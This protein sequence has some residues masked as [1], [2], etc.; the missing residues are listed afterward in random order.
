MPC[1]FCSNDSTATCAFQAEKFVVVEAREVK[2]GDT[3][4]RFQETRP[5]SGVA[6]VVLI[7]RIWLTGGDIILRIHLQI[8]RKNGTVR[9]KDFGATTCQRMRA[10]RA[11]PCGN[12]VCDAHHQDRGIIVCRE[13]WALAV[14]PTLRRR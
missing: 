4:K 5:K 9:F 1:A 2:L 8:R 7:E 6:T 10:L 13:H 12:S 11:A 3:V 14:D